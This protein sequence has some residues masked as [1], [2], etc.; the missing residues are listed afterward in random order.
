MTRR[1]K[2]SRGKTQGGHAHDAGVLANGLNTLVELLSDAFLLL[3]KN[4]NLIYMNPAAEQLLGLSTKHRNSDIGKNITDALPDFKESAVYKGLRHFLESG[5]PLT[6]TATTVSTP[7]GELRLNVKSLRL[8][9]N[10]G[11]ILNKTVENSTIIDT[12]KESETRVKDYLESSPDA[13]YTN[14]AK[15]RF[16]YGNRA[17]ERLIGYSRKELIGKSFLDLSILPEEYLSKAIGL[18]ELNIAGEPT[19]PDDFELIRKDGSRIFVE[20]STYPIQSGDVIE[21]IGIARDI[22]ERKAVQAELRNSQEKFRNVL[23]NSFD[24]VYRLNFTTGKYDYVSPSSKQ[25]LGYSPS[26]FISL[27]VEHAIASVHPDDRDRF[28]GSIINLMSP[29]QPKDTASTIEYRIKNKK[30]EYRWIAD[31]I[32]VIRGKARTPIAVV[33]NLRDITESKNAEE[34]LRNSEE[35]LLAMFESVTDGIT[36]TDLEGNILQLNDAVVNLHQYDNKE[37]LI[38]RRAFDLVAESDHARAADI[39]GKTLEEGSVN[40]IE[41]KF[42]TKDGKEFD[43]E[44]SAS[45]LRDASGD[46]IG[47]I[48]STRDIT[49]QK[50]MRQVLQN[51]E[52]HFRSLIEN[53]LEAIAIV[54]G[55]GLLT[56]ESPSF[57]RL[58]GYRLG[59]HMGRSPFDYIYSDDLDRVSRMFTDLIQN[60]GTIVHA[61]LRVWHEDGS[62]RTIEVVGQNLLANPAVSGIVANI[63]DITER[64][65]AEDELK[66]LYKQ[67]KEIRHQLQDEMKRRVDFTRALAHELK[68]P[69]TSVLA[70]SDLLA[71]EVS[72]E[73]L[74]TLARNIQQGA[75]NLDKRIDELLDLARGEIGMLQLKPE[76][77]DISQLLR[78][79]ADIVTPLAS[80]RGQSLVLS[81]PLSL[82]HVRADTT[83]LQQIIINLLNNA[84]KYTPIGG[85]IKLGARHKDNTLIIE[86]KDTGRGIAKE[87]QKW[88]FE[89]YHRLQ[90]D[91]SVGLGLGLALCKMLVELH[92][93]EIWIKSNIGRGSTFGFSLPLEEIGQQLIETEKPSK[94]WKVLLIEDDEKIVSSISVAFRM[95]WPEAELLSTGLGEEGTDLVE[96][97]DPDLVILDLGL[98]DIDGFDVLRQIRLFSSVPIVILTVKSEEEDMVKGL[99]WGADDYIVKPFRQLE[100]LA[101]LKS[102]LRKHAPFDEEAPITVGS[103]R[104]NPSTF[105][106]T[107]GS[108]EISLT[109]VEGRIM[110]HLMINA[111]HVV[112]HA[113]LVEAVWEEDYPGAVESLRVYIRHLREKLEP[114]PSNPKL[115]LTK[116]GIGYMLSKTV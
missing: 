103:L 1:S 14:D 24:M 11:I 59:D 93:G 100:L 111:G 71:A 86:V 25:L 31:N 87:E 30:G 47:F 99:D 36:V 63:R 19:G 28:S 15:G 49:E 64:K 32:S 106:L 2:S 60:Y 37:E 39:M 29:S 109:L 34:A 80:R 18:L 41:Y 115:I 4:L 94:L 92:G 113:R 81:L 90:R 35:K 52:E 82:P 22:T 20:I 42:V 77:V 56:Y 105:Q 10:I 66:Q 68:T 50:R 26:E 104:L 7:A 8:Q 78:Q 44:L 102:Q 9:D 85:N 53:S 95:R 55:N 69:L 17:A 84:I 21:V 114:D 46:P 61:E 27:G 57:E 96:T 70:S 6:T 40:Y 58:L 33:G 88:L 79:I 97:E 54:D 23:D 101:R 91:P 51:S 110:Q 73:P 72:E 67:E 5:E 108:K 98:P 83:R 74:Q 12:L 65:Q 62:L 112:T 3:D 45:V 89:P 48:A 43:A 76:P 38:G 116:V 16:I 107:Y 13:I 75:S